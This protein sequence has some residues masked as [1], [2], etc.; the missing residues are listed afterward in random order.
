MTDEAVQC[1][2]SIISHLKLVHNNKYVEYKRTLVDGE[3]D[4]QKIKN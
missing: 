1:C 2:I 3:K 4:V